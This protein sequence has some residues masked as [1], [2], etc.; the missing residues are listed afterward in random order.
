MGSTAWIVLY[1]LVVLCASTSPIPREGRPE[2][3]LTLTQAGKLEEAFAF[4]SKQQYKEAKTLVKQVYKETKTTNPLSSLNLLGLISRE[5]KDLK[6][7]L[8]YFKRCLELQ[9][10]SATVHFNIAHVLL[11]QVSMLRINM[12]VTMYA[13]AFLRVYVC[14]CR[15]RRRKLSCTSRR[16]CTPTRSHKSASARPSC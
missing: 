3:S 13:F 5:S 10:G 11:D 9:P 15:G 12:R 14:T 4:L 1:A 6:N 16:Q 8:K 2:K 7:A